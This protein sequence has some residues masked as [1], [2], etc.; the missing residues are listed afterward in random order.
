MQLA[1]DYY[2]HISSPELTI[3]GPKNKKKRVGKKIYI[4]IVGAGP[5]NCE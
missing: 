2:R 5:T 3:L 1:T 4:D